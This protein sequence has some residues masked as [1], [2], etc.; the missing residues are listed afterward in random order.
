M[1]M[2]S[3]WD[4]STLLFVSTWDRNTWDLFDTWDPSF[5]TW[6]PFIACDS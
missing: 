2:F 1:G 3:T 4:L 5:N 6:D